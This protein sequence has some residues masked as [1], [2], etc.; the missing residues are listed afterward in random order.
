VY[1]ILLIMAISLLAT[2]QLRSGGGSISISLLAI[3]LVLPQIIFG[4]IFSSFFRGTGQILKKRPETTSETSETSGMNSG[5]RVSNFVIWIKSFVFW[6]RTR[7]T[8][9][10][11]FVITANP[12]ITI[13]TDWF[14]RSHASNTPCF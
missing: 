4:F 10:F 8:R 9:N 2:I 13:K 1:V 7:T 6:T 12:T 3:S 11:Y 5:R 14:R